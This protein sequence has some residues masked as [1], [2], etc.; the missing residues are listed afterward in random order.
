MIASFFSLHPH[1]CSVFVTR[2]S[3]SIHQA[4]TSVLFAVW[5]KSNKLSIQMNWDEE[6]GGARKAITI[7]LNPQQFQKSKI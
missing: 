4:A 2:P 7:S 3:N 1:S 5:H 6:A